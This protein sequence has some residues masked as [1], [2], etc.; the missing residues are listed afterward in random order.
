MSIFFRMM[1]IGPRAW[2]AG[3]INKQ[4]DLQS[5]R[6]ILS[7]LLIMIPIFYV[8][9]CLLLL[10]TYFAIDMLSYNMND[11]G[12]YYY[13]AVS[14]LQGRNIYDINPAMLIPVSVLE[15]HIFLNLIPPH[16]TLLILPLALFSPQIALLLWIL[17]NLFCLLASLL[18]IF[19]KLKVKF[20]SW[21][22][23]LLVIGLLAFAGT[24]AVVFTGQLSFIMM[25]LI[26]LFWAESRSDRW[27]RAGIYLGLSMSIKL[28]L[29]IFFPYLLLRKKWRAV[30]VASGVALSCYCL[31]VMIFGWDNYRFWLN[32]LQSAKWSWGAMNASVQG[33]FARLL[34]TSPNFQPFF[35]KPALVKLLWLVTGGLIGVVTLGITIHDKSRE[36]VDR[37]YA[38]LLV[39]AQLISPLGWIYYSWLAFGPLIALVVSWYRSWQEKKEA[40]RSLLKV[41]NSLILIALLGFLI[42]LNCP[43]YFQ[44]NVFI[45]FSLG[46]AYFWATL[47]LWIG[48]CVDGKLAWRRSTLGLQRVGRL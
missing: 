4:K 29:L 27:V 43:L 45:T 44:P 32:G 16:F 21:R 2:F 17:I 23:M 39:A 10:N 36:E 26:T 47:A 3:K 6:W 13:S 5:V 9:A 34:A 41:R 18:I 12:K 15:Y 8:I 22:V 40:D 28:F 19:R 7:W 48:L 1:V 33:F 20:N 31:G 42:P 46:S 37:S 24:G 25:L 35:I 38:L 14:F 11:F 30:I